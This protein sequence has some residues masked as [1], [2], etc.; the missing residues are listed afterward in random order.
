MLKLSAC[1]SREHFRQFGKCSRVSVRFNFVPRITMWYSQDLL[2]ESCFSRWYSCFC[3]A[4]SASFWAF[5]CFARFSIATFKSWCAL[6]WSKYWTAKLVS[7]FVFSKMEGLYGV[8]P[9]FLAEIYC[10]TRDSLSRCFILGKI[11][12]SKTEP[13]NPVSYLSNSGSK[14]VTHLSRATHLQW[15]ELANDRI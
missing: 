15:Q 12:G 14:P 13:G 4:K 11:R 8:A 9:A 5:S 6:D 10:S 7:V 2:A 3:N 1:F